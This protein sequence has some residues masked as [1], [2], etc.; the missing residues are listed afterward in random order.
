VLK[1]TT[2]RENPE[3]LRVYLC[4][5]LTGEYVPELQKAL[6]PENTEVKVVID[7]FNVVFVDFE[8]MQYLCSV[9]SRFSIENP[10]DYIIR[11]I[12]VE[13]RCGCSHQKSEE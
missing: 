1:I 2:I 9:K 8:A 11:W 12:E 13:G 7:L 5:D 3:T 4:G 10:S 6:T